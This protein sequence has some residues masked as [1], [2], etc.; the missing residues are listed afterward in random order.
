MSDPIPLDLVR[1]R[2]SCAD[3]SLQMLCLPA[4]V[5]GPRTDVS[6]LT[7]YT[8]YSCSFG[9]QCGQIETMTNALSQLTSYNS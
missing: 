8:Y 4:S 7:T 5:D 1:L 3:C 2:R 9:N 6:D